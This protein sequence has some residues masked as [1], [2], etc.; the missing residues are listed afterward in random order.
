[1]MRT[2][3]FYLGRTVRYFRRFGGGYAVLAHTPKATA[4]FAALV[5]TCS[6][7]IARTTYAID[8][9]YGDVKLLE[10]YKYKRSS[11]VDTVNGVIYKEGGLSIEFESG[12]NEGYAANPK[13]RDKYTWYREQTV[14]GHKVMIALTKSGGGTAWEPEKPRGPKPRKI[15]MV[16]FPGKFGPDDAANFYAEVLNEQEI[17]DTL[18]MA[19]TFNPDK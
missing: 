3:S 16:T 8:Q 11:T 12:I 4:I 9:P 13:E 15:L 2:T 1:M 17:A 5:V 7:V 6:L 19:L 18:L 10:G 14:N